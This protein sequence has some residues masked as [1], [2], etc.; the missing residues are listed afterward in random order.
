MKRTF[1]IQHRSVSLCR[2]SSHEFCLAP[3]LMINFVNMK[4]MESKYNPIRL[5]KIRP[6]IELCCPLVSTYVDMVLIFIY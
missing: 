5:A 1:Y 2:K 4:S 6:I 3:I